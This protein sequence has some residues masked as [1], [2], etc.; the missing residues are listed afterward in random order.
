MPNYT[1][2]GMHNLTVIAK[3]TGSTA[4]TQNL[5]SVEKTAAM[6]IMVHSVHENETKDALKEAEKAVREMAEAGLSTVNAKSLLEEAKAQMSSWDYDTSLETSKNV[7]ELKE[8]TFHI[9]S[10]I[11]QVEEGIKEAEGFGIQAPESR[12]MAELSKSALQREDYAKAEER[13]SGAI[14]AFMIES[15]GLEN[16]RFVYANWHFMLAGSFLFAGAAYLAYRKSLKGRLKKRIGMLSE[17][18][19]AIRK[20]MEKAQEEMYSEKTLSRFEYHKLMSQHETRLAKIRKRKA[21]LTER[22]IRLGKRSATLSN[23]RRQ[24]ENLKREIQDLQKKYYEQGSVTKSSYQKSV[25]ELREELAESIHNI[26]RIMSRRKGQAGFLA[27]GF[28]LLLSVIFAGIVLAQ[29]EREAAINAMEKAQSWIRDMEQLGFPV[30]RANDTLNEARLLFSKE[31]YKGA[32]SLANDVEGIKSRA[33]SIDKKVDEAESSLYQAKSAGIDV[34]QPQALFDGALAAFKQEDYDRTE[35]ILSQTTARLEE[36]ESEYSMKKVAE[37]MGWEGL[38]KKIKDNML[39]I[40]IIAAAL[41]ATGIAAAKIRRKRKIRNRIRKLGGK[42]EKLNSMMKE[43]QLKY[44]EKGSVSES[45]YRTL[46]SR[47]RKKLT[48]AKRKKLTLE[49][50]AK[51]R[52]EK[53]T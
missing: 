38:L 31:F 15:Q 49:G 50:L 23:F 2:Y 13:A 52:E 16:M 41:I 32:E 44:F 24:E 9:S 36:L 48:A 37:G 19:K 4:T 33:I 35:D 17:E 39:P 21:R 45:E 26:D 42:E 46:M 43:L 18:E 11:I 5:T 20:L 30:N 1:S 22:L 53:S 34:S 3:A 25:D 12:K 10:L 47:Y 14:A 7:L 29:P 8:K 6:G 27:I 40:S 28:L 51:K